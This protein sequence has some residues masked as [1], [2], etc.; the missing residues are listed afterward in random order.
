MNSAPIIPSLSSLPRKHWPPS[1]HAV[2][3]IVIVIVLA[4]AALLF[5]YYY[6]APSVSRSSGLGA[7]LPAR[8]TKVELKTEYKNPFDRKTQYVNPFSEFKSS[9]TS[10]Q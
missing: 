7:L 2:I 4:A 8:S 3:V 9:F 5:G 10:L 1:K 6:Y